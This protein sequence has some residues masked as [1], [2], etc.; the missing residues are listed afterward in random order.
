MLSV[1][2]FQS[3]VLIYTRVVWGWPKRYNQPRS[4][5]RATCLF[6]LPI[7]AP[8]SGN[9]GFEETLLAPAL[10][11]PRL[12]TNIGSVTKRSSLRR[13]HPVVNSPRRLGHCMPVIID[14]EALR[15]SM[16]SSCI[17]ASQH[18]STLIYFTT[19]TSRAGRHSLLPLPSAAPMP[20][21]R[22]NR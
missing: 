18:P 11:S 7:H 13:A 19:L 5:N 17:H 8:C 14:Q 16:L 12:V 3:S 20:L 6:V 9:P 21:L 4:C 15:A 22:A 10:S 1:L 2:P